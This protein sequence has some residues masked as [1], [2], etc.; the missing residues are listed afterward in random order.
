MA[1][2]D[3]ARGKAFERWVAGKLGARRRHHGEGFHRYG[4]LLVHDDIV[5]ADGDALPVSFECKT[6][7]TLQLRKDWVDQA[8]RNAGPRPWVLV[9]RP[10]G[11]QTVYATVDFEFLLALLQEW[12]WTK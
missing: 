1:A 8:R 3:R 6:Y 7:A 12:G 4:G 5:E 2:K 11:S 9:Q 10:T